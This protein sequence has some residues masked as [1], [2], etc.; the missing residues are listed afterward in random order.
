MI[1]CC[2]CRHGAELCVCTP[3]QQYEAFELRERIELKIRE[4]LKK[5][6][7]NCKVCGEKLGISSSADPVTWSCSMYD[8][9]GL[10]LKE[11][12]TFMDKHLSDSRT[13]MDFGQYNNYIL[14]E[15]ILKDLLK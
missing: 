8:N 10:V 11:G 7:I 13:Y 4:K 14:I 15:N 5:L 6:P 12:R 9:D 2:N 3:D 1:R